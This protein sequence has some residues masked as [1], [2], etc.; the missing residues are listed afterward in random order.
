MLETTRCESARPE[1]AARSLPEVAAQPMRSER[2]AFPS[3]RRI[4]FHERGAENGVAMAQD[5]GAG[6]AGVAARRAHRTPQRRPVGGLLR[7]GETR[8][9]QSR[10]THM[11]MPMPP[12]MHSVARPFLASRLVISCSSVTST[13]APEA[14]IGW[15]SA[16]APPFTLTLSVSQ[17]RSLLTAQAWAA[18]ASLASIRSRSSA[19]QPARSSALREAGIGPVP[20]IDGSTPACAQDTIRASGVDAAPASPRPR[21]SAPPRRR[22]R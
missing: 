14:P 16:I 15:P 2:V 18:N 1:A 3:A 8:C 12:P 22:R 19:D 13:R 21:S 11:A 17:P 7:C 6:T 20:M 5:R 4:L 9:A 10:A